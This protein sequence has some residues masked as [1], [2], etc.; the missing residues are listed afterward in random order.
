M[1]P[2][3]FA[4]GDLVTHHACTNRELTRRGTLRPSLSHVQARASASKRRQSR[5]AQ[6]L[7]HRELLKRV[8]VLC[9]AAVV[10]HLR[11]DL[12]PVAVGN[13]SRVQP[14]VEVDEY[15]AAFFNFWRPG[16]PATPWVSL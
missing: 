14:L 9:R 3:E 2:V 6:L 5:Q 10:H 12:L 11:G 16:R 7:L 4:V 13:I 8:L 1:L 15:L